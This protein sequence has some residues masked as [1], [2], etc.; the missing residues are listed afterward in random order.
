MPR[1]WRRKRVLA[2]LHLQRQA[3]RQPRDDVVHRRQPCLGATRERPAR[4]ADRSTTTLT[5]YAG[6]KFPGLRCAGDGFTA[7]GGHTVPARVDPGRRRGKLGLG[8]RDPSDHWLRVAPTGSSPT[9]GLAAHGLAPRQ[10]LARGPVLVDRRPGADSTRRYRRGPG[11][12][13]AFEFH[14]ESLR[15]TSAQP[16]RCGHS[17]CRAPRSPPRRRR[18]TPRA[19]ARAAA[20]SL[21]RQA[22]RRSATS[23]SSRGSRRSPRTPTRSSC[24][25]T[26]IRGRR[27]SRSPPSSPRRCCRSA[28]TTAALVL[29]RARRQPEPHRPRAEAR[30]VDARRRPD[31][32]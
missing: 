30:L 8:R 29:P 20:S 14:D 23:R 7:D 31:H 5:S 13:T 28:R 21:R 1:P 32:R 17:A 19:S 2:R 26:S 4:P 12:R 24:R 15:R 16:A 25:V 27:S 11:S 10:R 6:G 22:S 18:R 9:P 3:V